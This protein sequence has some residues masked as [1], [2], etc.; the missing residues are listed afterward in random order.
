M[1]QCCPTD[2]CNHSVT[3]AHVDLQIDNNGTWQDAFQFG[4]PLDTTWTLTGQTFSMDVQLSAYDTVPLLHM[5][6][7]TGQIIIDDVI[8]R[9][10]HFNVAPTVLQTSLTPGSYVYDLV[11]LDGSTPP[12]RV[13][14]MHGALFV[15]QG[16]TYP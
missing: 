1:D 14:L 5:S 9:V 4:E 15:N 10:I 11:M 7:A 3:S 13:P 16:I 8:Q 12:I 6:S 2:G